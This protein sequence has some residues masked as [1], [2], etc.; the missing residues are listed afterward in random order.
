MLKKPVLIIFFILINLS[1]VI[2]DQITVASN[3]EKKT[4][5]HII[6]VSYDAA[7]KFWI[8]ALMDD[9][10][11]KN[12]ASLREEG[13]EIT[14]RIT[15]HIPATDPGQACIETGYGPNITGI[16]KNYFGSTVKRSI[17]QGLTTTERI[18]AVYGVSWKTALVMPW[19]QNF[20]N[21]TDTA[22]SV[23]WNQREE[24]DYWFSSENVTWSESAQEK[25]NFAIG[26]GGF[27][28]AL[29]RANYTASKLAEFIYENKD[30][31]FYGAIHFVEPDFRGHTFSESI[32]PESVE[33]SPQYKQSLIEC[34]DALGIII[35]ALKD[36]GMY[37][38]TVVLV[39]TDHGFRYQAHGP[40]AYP[41][42]MPDVTEIWLVS[43]DPEVTNELGWGLQN[44]LSPTCLGLAGIDPSN[45]Q[46]FY[47]ET[48]MALPLWKANI[49]NRETV[50][51]IIS[52][53]LYPE[54]IHEGENF[55]ITMNIQDQSGISIA[56]LR[57]KYGTIWFTQNLIKEN[58]TAYRGLLDLSTF[59]KGIEM[60]WYLRVADNS[61]S[62]NPAYY[63]EDMTPQVFTIKERIP[64]SEPPL[65]TDVEC[66]EQI[67]VGEVFNISV[68]AQ[69]ES[70]IS[71]VEIYYS[72]DSVWYNRD[73]SQ[74]S[75]GIYEGSV[76][77][78]DLGTEVKWYLN[79]TDNS[80]NYNMAFY[81]SDKQPLSF[82]V[83][84][85]SEEGVPLELLIIG[86]VLGGIIIIT[87]LYRLR[88]T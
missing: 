25:D 63:P 48:S 86:G 69:D 27:N 82:I 49:N 2:P 13:C 19:T 15:D 23:F 66:S 38:E 17:P 70:G 57:Y 9:G 40:P 78:F 50:P 28:T 6:V 71:S 45:F 44:D 61:P 42:G 5:N 8:D 10:T 47:N 33:I 30:N 32:P 20:V 54:S 68:N 74:S 53:I 7:R 21:V 46:P 75:T 34:D 83:Q 36:V 51:P 24:T 72:S 22:D 60:S 37:N 14:L 41:F 85:G 65:I 29:L 55:T 87:L 26:W 56:Q 4:F 35:D 76:G 64:E 43:N 52:D 31:N 77:P 67:S 1:I 84:D 59:V 12:L 3:S 18:K 58:D 79:A 39:T 81:P 62:L 73:M 80:A 11:L 16:D 88:R